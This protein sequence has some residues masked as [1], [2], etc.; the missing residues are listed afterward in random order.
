[1][2]T[3]LRFFCAFL[4]V[5][6]FALSLAI[7]GQAKQQQPAEELPNPFELYRKS[8]A[9][10]NY[11]KPLVELRQN[12]AEYMKSRQWR[13][14]APDLL[15]YL[16]SFAGEYEA[17]YQFMDRRVEKQI[18][19]PPDLQSS[20]F[21]GFAPCGALEAISSAADKRQVVMINE[22]HD[23]PLHRAFTAR[24]L[25]ALYKK[26]F[27]YLAAE[28]LDED[29]A[30]RLNRRGYPVT[31]KSGFYSDD[32]VFG[33]MLRLAVK[34][35]FKLVPYEHKPPQECVE[36]PDKPNFCQNERERGQAQNL[37]DRIFKDDP[38]AKVLV[39]VGRGHNQK[40]KFDDWAMMGWHFE[41]ITG[42]EPFSINQMM[43][44][45][46]ARKYERPEYRYATD[47]WKFDAPFTFASAA[48]EPRKA[49][50]YD[51]IVY[52]PRSR[53]RKGRPT[54]LLAVDAKRFYAV[55]MKKLNLQ[56]E[57]GRLKEI[58][59][60]MIQAFKQGESAD[61]VPID[62]IILYPNKEIP[63][64][65]LPEGKFRVRAIDK[66]GKITGEYQK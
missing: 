29:D 15:A 43:S 11:L 53:Y 46:S 20:P 4:S 59:P 42:I 47:K 62:Q 16:H 10:N 37:F 40:L 2:K 21:E 17:A 54:W 3:Q 44:E 66:T 6:L 25:P 64:L 31:R 48:G 28:T 39:H 30:E 58:E 50:G 52:H 7:K 32:P 36:Q 27:R 57:K 65:V 19:S 51:L 13:G 8:L 5:F 9:E 34:L 14:L 55:N 45:R 22:E 24:L 41:Q 49:L 61:A 12:E 35:G 38:Q 60:V 33:E 18:G 63:A 56:T 26:G 23:T 1:M